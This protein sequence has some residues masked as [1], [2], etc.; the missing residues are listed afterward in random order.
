MVLDWRAL[1]LMVHF[2]LAFDEIAPSQTD[3][4]ML[5]GVMGVYLDDCIVCIVCI[6]DLDVVLRIVHD[7]DS[8]RTRDEGG[9]YR[10]KGGIPDDC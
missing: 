1:W 9:S 10:D 8:N 4:G 5:A 7:F 3:I 2:Q 6:L